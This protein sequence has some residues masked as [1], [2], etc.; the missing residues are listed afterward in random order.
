MNILIFIC[1]AG[2]LFGLFLVFTLLTFSKKKRK[3][4][5]YL[6]WFVGLFVLSLLNFGLS[7]TRFY[8]DYP[9]TAWL[10]Y[11]LVYLYGPIL[12]FYVKCSIKP[13]KWS[14]RNYL[15]FI[16]FIIY[17][18]YHFP[19]FISSSDVKRQYLTGR[20]QYSSGLVDLIT[21]ILFIAHMIIYAVIIYK[22]LNNHKKTLRTDFHT[23][24]IKWLQFIV[25][26]FCSYITLLIIYYLLTMNG[27][28]DYGSFGCFGLKY[29]MAIFMFSI[30]YMGFKQPT[31]FLEENKYQKSGLTETEKSDVIT[32]LVHKMTN[33]KLYLENTLTLQTLADSVGTTVHVLSQSLNED[34]KQSFSE[35][36]NSYRINESK[37]LLL[38]EVDLNITEILY[39]CGFNNK[40]TFN[41]AFKKFVGTTPTEYKKR[42]KVA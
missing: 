14:A 15:H 17:L 29:L 42:M 3:S 28:L 7:S 40:A 35:F 1:Y 26:S 27:V 34:L 13:E 2:S 20:I 10:I 39:R 31:L 22:H 16:P 25:Y 6:V 11:P 12:Y 24:N 36:V 8:Y 19:F 18:A 41:T 38:T 4:N 30:G 33:E 9:H 23:V 37:K 5:I 21:I 32:K